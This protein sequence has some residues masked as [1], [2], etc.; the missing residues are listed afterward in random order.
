MN[1]RTAHLVKDDTRAR[2][3]GL[4]A[5]LNFVPHPGARVL[6]GT[7]RAPVAILL[8]S[9]KRIFLSE[10]YAR[11]LSGIM[12]FAEEQKQ[13]VHVIGFAL[14]RSS[15]INDQLTAATVGCGGIIYLAGSLSVREIVSLEKL[16]QPFVTISSSLPRG[17]DMSE[18]DIP[19]FGVQDFEGG[20]MVTK[21]LIDQ[22]HREIALL[23]GPTNRR[24]VSE[25]IDGFESA[26]MESGLA[27]RAEQQLSEDLSFEGGLAAT[28]YIVSLLDRVT[29]VVCGSDEQALGLIS[30][31][32]QAGIKCPEQVSVTGYDDA[33]WASRHSPSL[34]T[35]RQPWMELSEAAVSL[36]H[37][38][39]SGLDKPI[40]PALFVPELIVR[41][42]T[43]QV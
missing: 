34:T 13:S 9:K 30:G 27:V 31:F 11:L 21:H 41:E 5:E 42:T 32:K 24:D 38:S 1:P 36:L 6:R 22:G 4:A 18:F 7:A 16:S 29:A 17:L 15:D 3:Q 2:I 40:P 25:R 19:V 28:Q 43:R 8:R 10:Y 23:S 33:L 20:K 37:Q 12:H 26:M 14:D 35:I 39:A